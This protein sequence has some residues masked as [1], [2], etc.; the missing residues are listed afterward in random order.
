MEAKDPKTGKWVRRPMRRT[1]FV[2]AGGGFFED[3]RGG[4]RTFL[5]DGDGAIVTTYNR[6][7]SVIDNPQPEG[8][9]DEVWFPNL[10]A[11]PPLGTKVTVIL[12][13]V[14]SPASQPATRPATR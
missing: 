2:F 1:G 8:A 6:I 7:S 13:P 12:K 10:K 9:T 4:R 14:L 5:A 11:I 3:V